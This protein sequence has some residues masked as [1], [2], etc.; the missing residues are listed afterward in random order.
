M[1]TDMYDQDLQDFFNWALAGLEGFSKVLEQECCTKTMVSAN[2]TALVLKALSNK[3][4][5]EMSELARL[6]E[7]NFGKIVVN[8]NETAIIDVTLLPKKRCA[9][10][11]SLTV[12]KKGG[13]K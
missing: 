3:L 1:K 8:R 2:D 12:K 6:V 4:R 11:H 7:K 10:F 5:Y 13:V 9:L